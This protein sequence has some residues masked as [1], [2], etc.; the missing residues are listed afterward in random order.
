MK[1]LTCDTK[2]LYAIAKSKN[3]ILLKMESHLSIL[4]RKWGGQDF[5]LD[6]ILPWLRGRVSQLETTENWN[7]PKT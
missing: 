6:K 2:S 5:I 1:S 3:F 4:S 7:M